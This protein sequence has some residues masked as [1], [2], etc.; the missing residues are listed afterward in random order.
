MVDVT[1]EKKIDAP[2]PRRGLGKQPLNAGE[3]GFCTVVAA[4]FLGLG[5]DLEIYS[6]IVPS[7]VAVVLLAFAFFR[8][9]GSPTGQKPT[10]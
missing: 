10:F 1:G 5:L 8:R 6:L 9:L 4:L 7:S 2:L 3:L